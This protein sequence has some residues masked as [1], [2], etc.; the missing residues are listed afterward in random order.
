MLL[1]ISDSYFLMFHLAKHIFFD[2]KVSVHRIDS[3]LQPILLGK[4][5]LPSK[6]IEI[7]IDPNFE[8]K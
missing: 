5:M 2:L 8:I 4:S 6:L 3:V 1:Q 7:N